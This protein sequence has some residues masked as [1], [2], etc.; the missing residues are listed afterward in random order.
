[1]IDATLVLEGGGL[2]CTFTN[3]VLESLLEQGVDFA[4]VAGVSAGACAAASYVS[5][6]RGRNWKANVELASHPDFMGWRHLLRRGEYFNADFVFGEIPRSLVPFDETAFYANPVEL[7]V[8]A[9]S[10]ATG[11][12]LVFGK[13]DMRR[14]GVNRV[15]LASSSIPLLARG[16]ELDGTLCFDGGV[17]DSIPVRHGLSRGGKA[18][19]VLTRPRGYRKKVG[20]SSLAMRLLLRRHPEFLEA[21]ERRNALYNEQ[22]DDCERLEKEG[23]ILVLA[24]SPEFP[25]GRTERSFERRAAAYRHG[26]DLTRRELP[27]MLEFLEAR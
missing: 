20:R 4:R 22:L 11:R 25:V 19:V 16:V 3:G 13:D 24:P 1:M 6:Q 7:D 27:R 14:L 9:T 23:R 18:V 10:R 12:S 15:L 5:R 8:L 26:Q 2:R 21:V 17:A